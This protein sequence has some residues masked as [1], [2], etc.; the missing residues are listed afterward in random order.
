MIEV[1]KTD[2]EAS[3]RDKLVALLC[4]KFP[5][6]EISIDVTDCDKVLRINGNRFE[7]REVI[8]LLTSNG[9]SCQLL[10]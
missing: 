4:R 10:D 5:E 6:H 8:E 7:A 2:V 9:K 3:E 1:F